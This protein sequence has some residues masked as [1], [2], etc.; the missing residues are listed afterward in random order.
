MSYCDW[1]I[2]VK[3]TKDDILFQIMSSLNALA[4]WITIEHNSNVPCTLKWKT[5]FGM[6]KKLWIKSS[7]LLPSR[8]GPH[9]PLEAPS[10]LKLILLFSIMHYINIFEHLSKPIPFPQK[11]VVNQARE[12][13]LIKKYINK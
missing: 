7:Y 1:I 4:I 6:K 3:S 9:F 5:S 10:N 13:Q 2:F 11:M 12:Q 8:L